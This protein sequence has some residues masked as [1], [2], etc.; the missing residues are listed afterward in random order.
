MAGLIELC[1]LLEGVGGVGF[2]VR[3]GRVRGWCPE[4]ERA[5]SGIGRLIALEARVSRCPYDRS[6]RGGTDVIAVLQ[7]FVS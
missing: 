2:G 1:D 7:N 6:V 3:I 5:G 4:S